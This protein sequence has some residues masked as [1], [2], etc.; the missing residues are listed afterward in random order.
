MAVASLVRTQAHRDVL[1]F[2]Y[3][4]INTHKH[5]LSLSSSYGHSSCKAAWQHNT[6]LQVGPIII[7]NEKNIGEDWAFAQ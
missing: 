3:Y 6:E 2:L 1:H 7:K 4:S 5:K